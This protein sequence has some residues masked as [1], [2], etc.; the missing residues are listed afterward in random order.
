MFV[1]VYI[2]SH[3]FCYGN[4]PNPDIYLVAASRLR[5]DPSRC[6]VFEDALAGVQ[7]AKSAGMYCVGNVP[8][9]APTLLPVNLSPL[10]SGFRGVSKHTIFCFKAV[11]DPRLDTTPYLALTDIP[12]LHSLSQFENIANETFIYSTSP[13]LELIN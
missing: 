7:A 13:A 4:K 1:L 9:C 8:L 12:P 2:S 11:P 6:L 3:D 5:K 10:P